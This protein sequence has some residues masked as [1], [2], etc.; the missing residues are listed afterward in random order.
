MV[1]HSKDPLNFI[2]ALMWS[3]GQGVLVVFEESLGMRLA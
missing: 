2:L 3:R 1:S